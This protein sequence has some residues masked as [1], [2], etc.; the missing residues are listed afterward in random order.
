MSHHTTAPPT[1]NPFLPP[2][3]SQCGE[4]MLEDWIHGLRNVVHCQNS[5]KMLTMIYH[6]MDVGND[7]LG[8]STADGTLSFVELWRMIAQFRPYPHPSLPNFAGDSS[9]GIPNYWRPGGA[10]VE[11]CNTEYMPI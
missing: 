7:H 5:R 4:I 6:T 11:L 8:R 1:L 9:F 10:R 3:L 2:S